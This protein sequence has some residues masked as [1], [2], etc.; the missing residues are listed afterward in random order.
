LEDFSIKKEDGTTQVSDQVLTLLLGT[1]FSNLR[2][3]LAV[4]L[5]QSNYSNAV[6]PVVDPMQ[7]FQKRVIMG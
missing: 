5:E 7:L 4:K 1:S 2:G 6:L 3:M